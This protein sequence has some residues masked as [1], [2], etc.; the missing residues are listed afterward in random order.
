MFVVLR[1]CTSQRFSSLLAVSF[2]PR[3]SS[4]V[5]RSVLPSRVR[6]L[7][8]RQDFHHRFERP[9]VR[10]KSSSL[11][12]ISF[13]A[14]SVLAPTSAVRLVVRLSAP[15]PCF[16]LSHPPCLQQPSSVGHRL[17][18][19][20]LLGY[21]RAAFASPSTCSLAPRLAFLR[22]P[23]PRQ[24]YRFLAMHFSFAHHRHAHPSCA[25]SPSLLFLSLLFS[26][27]VLPTL[28]WIMASLESASYS[29]SSL[30]LLSAWLRFFALAA[31]SSSAC[32]STSR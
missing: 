19:P 28:G 8:R 27:T 14:L 10:C 26:P 6:H 17:L 18:P 23:R 3:P 5:L 24:S 7:P 20:K 22:S 2:L 11:L 1:L 12:R 32:P 31:R 25:G 9:I 30:F 29:S 4:L 16:L 21:I 15:S 13:L